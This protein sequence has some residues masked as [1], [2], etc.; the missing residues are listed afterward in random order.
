M[1][2]IDCKETPTLNRRFPSRT[3][4]VSSRTEPQ[5]QSGNGDFFKN[6][7]LTPSNGGSEHL[8]LGVSS[9]AAGVAGHQTIFF[10]IFLINLFYLYIYIKYM[11]ISFLEDILNNNIFCNWKYIFIIKIERG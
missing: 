4:G 10:N 9:M 5:Q 1:K 7:P 3:E 2:A 11:H 6:P 8:P